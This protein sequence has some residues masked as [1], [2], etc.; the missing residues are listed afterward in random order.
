VFNQFI[1]IFGHFDLAIGA[2]QPGALSVHLKSGQNL[3]QRPEQIKP[4][5]RG[6]ALK[7]ETTTG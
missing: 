7:G 3:T 5:S 2:R 6:K 1:R 4:A